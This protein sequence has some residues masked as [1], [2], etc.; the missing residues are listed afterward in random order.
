M[1]PTDEQYRS[2]I[3]PRKQAIDYAYEYLAIRN[4]VGI[5]K[6][7]YCQLAGI[8]IPSLNSWLYQYKTELAA[9]LEEE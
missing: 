5:T 4:F 7:K 2:L 8:S 1:K 9:Q 6:N 3:S